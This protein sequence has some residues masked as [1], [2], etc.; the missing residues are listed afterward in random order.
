MRML[1]Y[2]KLILMSFLLT[3]VFSASYA[4]PPLPTPVGRV[5][6]ITGDSLKAVMPNKEE[7]ILQKTSVIYLHDVL[8]T[9]DKT[10]AE[11]VFTDN[12]LMTFQVNSRFSV[13][14]YTFKGKDKKGS[15]GKS[16]MRLIEG[17]FRTITG[18]IAKNNPI[19]YAVNTPVATIGVRGTDYTVQ[20]KGGEIYIAFKTGKPC[21]TPNKIKQLCLDSKTPYAK[22]ASATSAPEGMTENQ[23]MYLRMNYQSR[24]QK[25]PGLDRLGVVVVAVAVV[26]L[27]PVS[28][29][30]SN[31]I[32][33]INSSYFPVGPDEY[34]RDR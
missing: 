19:D 1:K 7:R 11:I 4:D 29:S 24:R 6:W 26:D 18:L 13:D 5:V 15:V 20:L 30:A 2:L 34:H 8:V 17:G 16:V 33:E 32:T 21:V 23:Q 10:K 22:V 27:L 14:E 3:C 25:F 28:A 31:Y 9:N 12:T